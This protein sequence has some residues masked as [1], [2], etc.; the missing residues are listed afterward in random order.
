MD[1]V[2]DFK[3]SSS[4]KVKALAAC[5]LYQTIPFLREEHIVKHVL[6]SFEE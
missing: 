6:G 3:Y 1:K 5:S 4:R 2:H